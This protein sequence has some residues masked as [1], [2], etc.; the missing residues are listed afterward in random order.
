MDV[1]T[2]TADCLTLVYDLLMPVVMKGHSKNT[3]S[4]QEVWWNFPSL[5]HTIIVSYCYMALDVIVLYRLHIFLIF[6]V[7]FLLY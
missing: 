5:K 3:L 2:P 1:A 7:T 6:Q 4:H